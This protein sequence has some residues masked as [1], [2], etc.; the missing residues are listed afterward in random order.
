MWFEGK[1][2]SPAAELSK[3]LGAGFAAI[4]PTQSKETSS[5]D[6]NTKVQI[7][8][9]EL[10]RRAPTER[11]WQEGHLEPAFRAQLGPWEE[12]FS[13]LSWMR[14]S[15]QESQYPF[16]FASKLCDCYVPANVEPFALSLPGREE[17]W[18]LGPAGGLLSDLR[19]A[20]AILGLTRKWDSLGKGEYVGELSDPLLR[21]KTVAAIWI[22]AAEKSL[23]TGLP[24][25]IEG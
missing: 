1:L 8:L 12:V 19:H 18:S 14:R 2:L 25:I 11:F 20:A 13:L 16:T 15:T 10:R 5:G 9:D 4:R 17:P 7:I 24:L 6:A 23:A 22:C 3:K 21:E